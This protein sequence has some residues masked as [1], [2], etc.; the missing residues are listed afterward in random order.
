MAESN[1]TAVS[2]EKVTALLASKATEWIMSDI[3]D[4][5]INAPAG[6]DVG[7][8][9]FSAMLAI[10]QTTDRNGKPAL[11]ACTQESILSSL[12]DMA[13][14]GISMSKKQCYPIIYGSTLNIL[15]SY[16]GTI[17]V[18][19]RLFPDYK[20]TA[21]VLYEGDEYV[22]MHDDLFDF[23]YIVIKSRSLENRDKPIVAAYG[24]IVDMTKRERIYGC[25]MTMKEIRTSWSHAKTDKVQKEFPQEMA[26][27][28]LINRMLKFY[29]NSIPETNSAI[30]GAFNRSTEEE[31]DYNDNSLKNVTPEEADTAR[32][33]KSRSQGEKGLSSILQARKATVA[34]AS[35]ETS[36]KKS[37]EPIIERK[38][39]PKTEQKKVNDIPA[40]EETIDMSTGEIISQP[41]GPEGF[42]DE[43]LP[44]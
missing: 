24:S 37:E 30:A 15:R 16:F 39:N 2:T 20:V 25:V 34:K 14:Q 32:I 22:M 31:Y 7:S 5:K 42:S 9:M 21:D 41:V 38:D 17:S 10:A 1:S 8:E 19:N 23:D 33:L 43:E 36:E 44:F 28:T 27:R 4:G 26:K 6:Y 40:P 29:V 12:R 13:I 11:Q 35:T 3:K 18:F